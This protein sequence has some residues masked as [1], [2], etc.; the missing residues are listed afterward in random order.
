MEPVE[1][2]SAASNARRNRV[3]SVSELNWSVPVGKLLLTTSV[4]ATQGTAGL[5]PLASA[6]DFLSA[7]GAGF[8]PSRASPPSPPHPTQP[9]ATAVKSARNAWCFIDELLI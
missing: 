4:G 5:P 3:K 7:R 1:G 6:S 2:A 8:S 9:R